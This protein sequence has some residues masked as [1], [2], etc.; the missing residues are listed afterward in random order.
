M[1]DIHLKG[2][3][4]LIK[5]IKNKIRENGSVILVSSVAANLG[6]YDPLYSTFKGGVNSMVKTLA[7]EFKGKIR[8]NAISPSLIADSTVYHRMTEDFRL[9][10]QNSTLS[11]RLLQPG[12]VAGA[13]FFLVENEHINGQIIHI[14]GGQYFGN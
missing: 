6:S 3:I 5:N 4:F 11:K 10:H 7:R 1:M 12:E 8:V 14:N 2:P 13:I 9:K